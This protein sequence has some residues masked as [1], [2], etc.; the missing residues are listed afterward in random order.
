MRVWTFSFSLEGES[1]RGILKEDFM[2]VRS[3]SAEWKGALKQGSGS[4]KLG[5]GA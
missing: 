1:A 4:M 5:S 2:A 3:S